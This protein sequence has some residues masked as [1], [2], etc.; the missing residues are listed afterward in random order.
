MTLDVYGHPFP[1]AEATA[2]MEVAE[3]ASWGQQDDNTGAN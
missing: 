3:R 1:K 2:E